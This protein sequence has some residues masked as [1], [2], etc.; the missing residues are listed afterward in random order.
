MDPASKTRLTVTFYL[1]LLFFSLAWAVVF[2]VPAGTLAF[3]EAWVV[4]GILVIPMAAGFPFW[5]KAD[6]ALVAR[7]AK[8]EE[9]EPEQQ[10]IVKILSVFFVLTF[11]I[12]GFDRRFDWSFVPTFVVVAADILVALGF[13]ICF[14]AVR[15][16]SYA[17]RIILVEQEQRV[18]SSGLYAL[19]RHP[20]YM[21]AALMCLFL[22]LALGSYWAVIPALTIIPVFAARIFN[23]ENFLV[24]GLKGYPEYM[25]KTRCRL[26]P[27]IW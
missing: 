10:V 26:I 25:Q 9:R 22:P 8:T 3:W 5:L 16:N 14:E 19:V 21:G 20:M 23:E 7:R 2:F 15:E 18:I 12:P 27:G 11:L 24:K 17:S 1:R 4:L 6:P 13:G